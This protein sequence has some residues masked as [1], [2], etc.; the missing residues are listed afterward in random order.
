MDY[1]TPG[2]I[3][4]SVYKG[5]GIVEEADPNSNPLERQSNPKPLEL[6]LEQKEDIAWM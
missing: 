2:R 5:N 1:R 3:I 4:E 6:T